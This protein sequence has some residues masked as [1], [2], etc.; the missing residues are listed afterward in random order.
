M[1]IYQYLAMVF[2]GVCLPVVAQVPP[3][4]D[5]KV[6]SLPWALEQT[7][8]KNTQ[9]QSFSYDLKI[10]DANSLQ[11]AIRP[12]PTLTA[13]VQNVFGSGEVSGI[14]SAE[15]SLVLSQLIEL[16]GKRQRRIDLVSAAK[17]QHVSDFELIRL[18]ALSETTLRYY[19]LLRV[20]A[21]H[22]WSKQRIMVEQRA[23]NVIKTRAKAGAVIAADVSKMALRLARSKA[24]RQ[25]LSHQLVVAKQR[26]AAMWASEVDF[27]LAGE[28]LGILSGYPSLSE[29]LQAIDQAPQFVKLLNLERLIEAQYR[30]E[31]SK[32]QYDIT[33][34]LG[35]KRFEAFDDSALMLTFSMPIPLTSPNRGKVLATR[36][37][38]E[39]VL[40]QQQLARQQIRLSLQE[41]HQALTNNV[42]QLSMLSQQVMPL[43]KQLLVDTEAAY[44]IGQA[45]VLQLGDAQAELFSVEREMIETNI[46]TYLQLIELERI[47]GQSMTNGSR[48]SVI[49]MENQ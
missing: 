7:L 10:L 9:L 26:L 12:N 40:Q 22:Q 11:A 42:A 27:E 32:N 48:K 45:T 38:A 15:T 47:T 14:R 5:G 44:R 28:R 34:G 30:L 37:Q 18:D 13:S 23:L 36:A 29:V 46:A 2:A 43:A 1:K 33:L 25:Q 21:L 19:Q 31:Q 16:G 41:I 20:Q 6:I 3:S 8:L 4:G 39:K 17:K 49:A 35:V 24:V